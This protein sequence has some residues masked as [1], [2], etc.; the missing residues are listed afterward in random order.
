MLKNRKFGFIIAACFA[1]VATVY[2][3]W[4]YEYDRMQ[5]QSQQQIAE[6]SAVNK[7]RTN[8]ALP[9]HVQLAIIP[10]DP[11]SEHSTTKSTAMAVA[12][13]DPAVQI[14]QEYALGYAYRRAL[15]SN[16][17]T[18]PVAALR[19]SRFCGKFETVSAKG[20][21]KWYSYWDSVFGFEKNRVPPKGNWSLS[22]K[23]HAIVAR[24]IYDRCSDFFERDRSRDTSAL[25]KASPLAQEL[26]KLS[27]GATRGDGSP[28]GIPTDH[29]AFGSGSIYLYMVLLDRT[30]SFDLPA[31]GNEWIDAVARQLINARVLC[32][33]GE[34]CEQ[35]SFLAMENCFD[36]GVCGSGRVDEKLFAAIAAAGADP[37]KYLVIADALNAWVRGQITWSEF[38]RKNAPVN[39]TSKG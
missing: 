26:S 34:N 2:Y 15:E 37:D 35:G 20:F 11:Q 17:P 8:N 13:T 10:T 14:Q 25:F 28:A 1:L 4:R 3:L 24:E 36:F 16:D 27:E 22:A 29:P 9:A 30:T 6:R 23:A 33:N 5:G 31:S 19:I 32:A 12:K 18:G 39:S 21:D 38:V 7:T